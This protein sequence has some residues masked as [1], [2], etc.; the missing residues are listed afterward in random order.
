M[1]FYFNKHNKHKIVLID[2][3]ESLKKENITFDFA[4]TEFDKKKN[5]I[6]NLK[7]KI[8]QEIININNSYDTIFNNIS[9]SFELKHK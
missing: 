1:C 5:T 8:E 9:K 3:E 6:N 4:K 7:E 2:D